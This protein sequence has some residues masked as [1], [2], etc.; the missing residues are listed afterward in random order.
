MSE[1]DTKEKLID[2][3]LLLGVYKKGNLQLFELPITD[4]EE[5]IRKIK[6]GNSS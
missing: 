5:E 3:L 1:L 2:E 6:K 4:L